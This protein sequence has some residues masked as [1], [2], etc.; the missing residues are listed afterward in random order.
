MEDFN[1]LKSD[2]SG[3]VN[4]EEYNGI[5]LQLEYMQKDLDRFC[6]KKEL[7]DRFTTLSNDVTDRISVRPTIDYLRKV[8]TE[9]DRKMNLI[10]EKMQTQMTK[11]DNE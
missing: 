11:L 9:Y 10:E 7:V 3:F 5:F 6:S 8:L 2:Y 4:R 1:S